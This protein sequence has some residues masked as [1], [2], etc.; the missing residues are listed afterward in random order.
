VAVGRGLAMVIP[1]P[2]RCYRG[3]SLRKYLTVAPVLPVRNYSS[4]GPDR[5][6]HKDKFALPDLLESEERSHVAGFGRLVSLPNSYRDV[7]HRVACLSHPGPGLL[8]KRV[9][10][11][12][13]RVPLSLSTCTAA[14]RNQWHEAFLMQQRVVRNRSLQGFSSWLTSPTDVPGMGQCVPKQVMAVALPEL[15]GRLGAPDPGY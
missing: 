5:T 14:A 11:F 8:A 15:L 9:I 1:H 12:Q 2:C 13:A 3:D 10:G 7:T 6:G 4:F